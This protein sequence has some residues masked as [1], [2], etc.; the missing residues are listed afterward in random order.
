MSPLRRSLERL[1]RPGC[2]PC[3]AGPPPR[4]RSRGRGAATSRPPPSHFAAA[5]S[6]TWCD[7]CGEARGARQATSVRRV[8]AARAWRRP[9]W[10]PDA[11]PA[12]GPTRSPRAAA[13]P[14]RA[15]AADATSASTRP[16]QGSTVGTAMIISLDFTRHLTDRAA[17]ERGDHRDQPARRSRCVG[18]WFGDRRLDLRPAELLAAGHP[19]HPPS[20][21]A[22]ASRARPAC[23]A[24]RPRTCPSPSAATSAA[25]WTRP[26]TP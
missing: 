11:G 4:R 25:P 12:A 23:A 19:G 22:R 26:R 20:A 1:L 14:P 9:C 21:A 3:A 6:L 13:S 18:H 2:D 15:R 8:L 24:P 17:V 10:R 5:A 7:S 16:E